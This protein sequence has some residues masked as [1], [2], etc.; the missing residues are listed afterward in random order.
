LANNLIAVLSQVLCPRIDVEGMMAG[1]E[2]MYLTPGIQ[3]LVRENK[4]FRIDSEIQTGKKYGMVLLDDFLWT[5]YGAGKISKEEAIDKSKNPS[6]MVDRM[7][8]AGI[9]VSG[10]LEDMEE[11]EPASPAAAKPAAASGSPAVSDAERKAEIAKNRA[12]MQAQKAE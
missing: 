7:R 12:R 2:F 11:I 9:D 3:N 6:F 5:I 1:Y 10:E 8:R 4:V